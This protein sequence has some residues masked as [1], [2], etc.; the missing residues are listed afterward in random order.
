MKI[1][2]KSLSIITG[3]T[4]GLGKALSNF[5]LENEGSV[6][7]VGRDFEKISSYENGLKAEFHSA[8]YKIQADV[9][10]ENDL[11]SIGSSIKSI[12]SSNFNIDEINLFNNASSIDPISL[13]EDVSFDQISNALIL[14]VSSAY[15]LSSLLLNIKNSTNISFL[16]I[17]NI[18]SGVSINPV[19]G[20]SAYCI[21][22]AGLNMISKC[23]SIECEDNVFS[24]S[25]N[26]GA[27][28]TG[29]QERIRSADNIKIPATKKFESMYNEGKLQNPKDVA[30]KLFRVLE[31]NSHSN[32]DF[33]DFNKID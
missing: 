14:N 11:N 2:N 22:K 18:S 27:I 29:M 15:T 26:P 21:S 13:M 3:G 5:I 19:K 33:I 17:I 16:N 32:G 7:F 30:D 4:G 8:F 31:G 6:L 12:I 24:L 20:W 28:D 1:S 25:I 23:L 9:S 10:V